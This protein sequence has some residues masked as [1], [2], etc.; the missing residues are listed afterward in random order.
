[1]SG[2]PKRRQLGKGLSALLGDDADDLA[3]LDKLRAAKPVPIDLIHPG[4]YQP[5]QAMNEDSLSELSQSIAEKGILQPILVRR[6][7]DDATTYEI[8]AGERRWRAAQMANLHEVP[9]L[10][11]ELEDREALEIALV[12]N[13]QRQDLSP[14]DEANGY[15]R[16]MDEFAHNQ[17]DLARRVGKSRSHVANTMRLLNLPEAV[18]D[19]V[20]DGRLTAGHARAL[21]TVAEPETLAQQVVR[22]N[23]NVR[24][25][26]ALAQTP[27]QPRRSPAT[28][29]E[30]DADTL[31]LERDLSALLGVQV[32]I[33][34]KGG[35]GSL[36]LF[37]SSLD[38]LDDLLQRLSHGKPMDAGDDPMDAVAAPEDL[39]TPDDSAEDV[40]AADSEEALSEP[41]PE[42]DQGGSQQ[43]T[44][45][46]EEIDIGFEETDEATG[47]SVTDP[48]P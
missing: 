45:I 20:A 15:R 44:P 25:T 40:T 12:E 9:V 16:L 24:Q 4:R 5:R 30:K 19:M 17:E 23:L 1:M 21:L 34:F 14:L 32:S 18:K 27:D 35:R 37:Y 2:D 46:A 11:R 3:E 29:S 7:P 22:K 26:E 41:V 43:E 33:R 47:V 31:A 48:R 28:A 36:T 39:D 13:L 6:D 10:I 42:P 8:V 38:Q